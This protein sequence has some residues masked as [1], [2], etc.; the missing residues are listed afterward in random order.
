MSTRMKSLVLLAAIA[1]TLGLSTLAMASGFIKVLNPSTEKAEGALVPPLLAP[2]S[3]EMYSELPSGEPI[4]PLDDHPIA[5]FDE[6]P[7]G[8]DRAVSVN[9]PEL[10]KAPDDS[11][12][13]FW[14]LAS[15]KYSGERGT[16]LVTTSRPSS[17]AA[18]RTMVLGT[19]A[20]TL[21]NGVTAWTATETNTGAFPS[22]VAFVQDDLIVTIA[23]DLPIGELQELAGDVVVGSNSK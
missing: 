13:V 23:G 20:V 21:S 19:Q 22:Q 17:A 18:S 12:I 5:Q 3:S 6:P 11:E 9:F 4:P 7:A 2:P 16:I 1:A 8:F 14:V 15:T 10:K